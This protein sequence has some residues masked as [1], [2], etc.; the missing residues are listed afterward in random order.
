M[1]HTLFKNTTASSTHR[2]PGSWTN[3]NPNALAHLIQFG[4]AK[5]LTP[6]KK[7]KLLAP[8]A[9]CPYGEVVL[10]SG[11]HNTKPKYELQL[12]FFYKFLEHLKAGT[13]K[14]MLH[15]AHVGYV[16][17]ESAK[18]A[19]N[20]DSLIDIKHMSVVPQIVL[21]DCEYLTWYTLYAC[22]Q[23]STT[24]C[25]YGNIYLSLNANSD[26]VFN[27]QRCFFELFCIA[28][29]CKDIF[30]AKSCDGICIAPLSQPVHQGLTTGRSTVPEEL[31]LLTK[32]ESGEL[33]T[34]WT[35]PLIGTPQWIKT[36]EKKGTMTTPKNKKKSLCT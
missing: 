5:C 31:E 12:Y 28:R 3:N 11:I 27:A 4:R 15:A 29:K 25:L 14:V 24:I 17:Q 18:S 20:V 33:L 13:K 2:L 35:L 9:G 34:D 21:T 8:Y 26:I 10:V 23:K 1:G 22:L 32:L 6:L 30:A 16:P 7:Q 19:R 36:P